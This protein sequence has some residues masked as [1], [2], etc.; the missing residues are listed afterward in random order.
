MSVGRD[1]SLGEFNILQGSGLDRRSDEYA[2][3]SDCNIAT[4]RTSRGWTMATER[5][6]TLKF[7]SIRSM[8][9]A[10][11]ASNNS[12]SAPFVTESWNAANS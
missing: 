7:P 5:E 4:L 12:F 2:V 6:A 9:N 10:A 11:H 1:E 8:V 3:K